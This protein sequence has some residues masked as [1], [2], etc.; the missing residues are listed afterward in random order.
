MKTYRWPGLLLSSFYLV[1]LYVRFG[2]GRI[3]WLRGREPMILRLRL[4]PFFE[5][6]IL[7]A[8]YH[9]S[10]TAIPLICLVEMLKNLGIW[11]GRILLRFTCVKRSKEKQCKRNEY[12]NYIRSSHLLRHHV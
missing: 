2:S 9:Y 6:V 11:N 10:G 1:T 7:L 8:H 5:P 12:Q 3:F 4:R